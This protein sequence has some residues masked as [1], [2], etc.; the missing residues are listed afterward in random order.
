MKIVEET[1]LAREEAHR[2]PN[3]VNNSFFFKPTCSLMNVRL[4]KIKRR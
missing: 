4:P 2:V 3:S 1:F